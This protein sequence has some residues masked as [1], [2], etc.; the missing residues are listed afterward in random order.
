LREK[1]ARNRVITFLRNPHKIRE[2]A[3]YGAFMESMVMGSIPLR[4]T[5][6][7]LEKSS[8]YAGLRGSYFFKETGYLIDKLSIIPYTF[9]TENI[10]SKGELL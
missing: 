1:T 4:S 7:N 2:N 10:K 9:I 6:K 3:I 8:V 5:Y